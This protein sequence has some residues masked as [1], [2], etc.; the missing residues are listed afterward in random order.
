MRQQKF[1]NRY[2]EPRVATPNLGQAQ[3]DS[4]RSLLEQ[5][6]KETF[7]E[8][9][10]IKDY[11][12][13]KFDLEFVKIEMGEPKYDEHYAKAQKLTLDIPLRAIVRLKNKANGSEKE[14]E[15]FLADMPVMTSHGTFVINGVERVIVPQLA[16]S[17]GVF[18]T[19]EE[20]K[21]KRHFGAKIIPARGAWIEI[22][23]AADNEIAVRIDRK[24][25]FPAVSLLRVLG[26]PYDSDLKSLFSHTPQEKQWIES[27]IEKDT[28][29]TVDEAY[30]EIHKRL[31]DGDL[32]TSANAREYIDS[33]FSEER[34]DLSRVGRYRFNQRF[35]KSLDEKELTRKTLSL[36]DVVTVLRQVIKLENDPEAVEDN[37]DHLGS[38]RVRYVGEML[39]SRLRV[40]LTHMKRNIQDRMSTIDAEATMPVQFVNPRPLQARIKEFFTTNQLSQFAQQENALTELEHL[41][42]L[43]AL[44]P[45]GLTRERAGFEVRDVHPSHY[46][47][48]CP[49]Q[50][51]EGPNIGLI[52]RLAQFARLN[53]FGMIETPY[54]K[55][56]DGK[57]TKEVVY[58]N[59]AEEEKE[60]IAHAG[61]TLK[62]DGTIQGDLVEVRLNGGPTRVPRK[63][64][65]YIDVAPEQPFSI[66]TS[67]IPFLEHDDANRALMGSNMQ[68]Q[69]TPCIIPEAP[70]VATGIEERA[71]K[72]TGR[73][74]YALEDGVVSAVDGKQVKVKNAKGKETTYSLV[75]F[76]RTNGFTALHQRPTVSVGDKVKKGD[77]LADTSTSDNGQLALGQN[78]LV[79]FMC[80][81]GANYE[82]AIIISER[83]V[84]DS[85]FSSIHIEEFV[86][87]VR[88]T[89]LG[90]EETTHDIPN[91]SEVKLRNLDEDGIVRVGS[92]VRAGDILVGKITPKG[93]TQLTPE[94]RLLRSIFG[95]KARDVKDSS[96]RMENGKRGRI[97]G[98][99]VF[100]REAGHNLESGII[101]R[102][103]IEVAQLRAVSVGDK[104]A[105]RHGNKGVISRILPEEDMPYMAD[106]R[107]VDVILTPLGVPS[108]MNLGQIL[109]LHLGLAANTLNYQAI[110]PPFAGA[111][112]GEIREELK[113]AG[114]NESGKMTL[115][116]GR[117]GEKFEQDVSV[118]YMYIL[119]LHHMVED[120]IHMRS[121]GPYSLITQQ[122]LGGKAQGGGQRFG[123]MEVWALLGY[124]AAY[125]LREMLTIKSDDIQGR[126]AAFDAI[127]RGERISHHY[128][129]A[130]FNVLLHT[131][132]GLA[133]DIELM[134]GGERVSAL[135]KTPGADVSDFDNVR[136]RPA[137]PER[138][139][140]WSHGEVTKPETIN[141]RTQRPE[142]NSLFDEKIF[143]PEKDY[144]CY[145][146]KYRGI[147]YKGITCEK[148][149]VEITRAIV[150]RER[151]GHVDLAV[152]VAHVWFL[153]AIPS[154]LAM[155][156]GISGGDLEKV[157]YFAGYVVTTVHKAEK[158]RIIQELE[159]EYKTK[160]KNLVDEKSKEKM[161]ELFLEAKRDIEA[162]HVG[163]VLDEPRYHRYAIKYGAM[164]E[165]GIGA[166]AIYQL[167]RGLDLKQ[168]V[169][170]TE[171]AL[172][173]AGAAER[174][175]LSKRLSTLRSMVRANV[176]PEWMFLTR[177]P[178][179]PPGLRPM[180]ALDG[181]RHATSDVNDLYRRVINRNNRLKKL[182]EINA[183][184]VILRNEKRILQEAVDA[185]I[186]NSIRHG[187]AAYSATTQARTRP[188]KSLSDNLKGKHGLFRQNLLGKRVDYSGRSVIVVGPELKLNQCGLPKH[189]ALELFRPF[190]IGQLLQKELAYNIR[191]AGRLIDEG[192]PEV[193]AI[194]EE[195]IRD[196][197]VLLNR[198][199]TLHRLGIQAFQPILIEGNAIQ[200]HPMVC[201]AF[202]ADF[203]GDQMAVHVPL[204]PEAQAEA[205]EIMAA[206]KNVLKPG[207][208]EPVVASKLL[209]I[210]LGS[211]WM[212]K[213]VEG[214]KGEGRAFHSPNAAIL[215]YDHG[216]VG[217]Q[218]KI[219][220]MPS[221]KEKYAQFGGQL[222]ETTV[223]RLL[224][225]T[226]FPS[227]Y[228]YVNASIDKK[229][230]SKLVDDLIARYG[231]EKIPEILDRIK[232]FGF[233]YVTQSGIT[234]SLDD[235]KIPKEK[236]EIVATAQKKSDEIMKHWQDGLLSEE[237]RYRMNIEVWHGAKSDVE[238][239][240]PGTLT[241]NGPVSDMLKSGARGSVAQVTQ[242]AG[243]KGLIASPTGEAI[244]FPITKS[245]KEGLSPIEYFITTHGS[246]KGLSDT[247]LNTAKAGYLTRRLFDVAQDVVVSEDDCGTKE[248]LTIN[249]ES[250]SGIGTFLAQN[251]HGRYLAHDIE[252]GGKVEYKKGH[253][254]THTDAKRIEELGVPSVY[255]RS[256]VA[257]KSFKGVCAKCYGADLGTMR[258][259]S[260]GEAVGTV[261]AQAIGEPGTQLTM[262]TFHAGGAASVGGDITQGLPRVEEIFERR[263][264][265]NPAVIATVGGEVID[266]KDDG[267]EKI[268]SVA[269]DV[270][271]MK[272]GKKGKDAVEY[273]VHYRRI[274]LVKVGDKV[275]KGQFLTDGSADLSELFKYAGKEK[276]LAYIIAE[277]VKIYELQG[278]NISIKHLEVIVRQMF[279]R[280]KITNPGTT[281]YSIGDVVAETEL[282]ATN[283]RIKAAGGEAA[284]GEGL[285]MGI[286]DVS[287]SR[288]SFLSAASFQNTTRMLIKASIG[289][290][291]DKLEGLKENVII[292][293]L[294]PAGTGFKGSPKADL[295]QKYSP[296]PAEM[297]AVEKTEA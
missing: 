279:S 261:A 75:N 26:A 293:R 253:F 204:S 83:L 80:W 55:V 86:C 135:R 152:P 235:I 101:K 42:T 104:L 106:G 228:P 187:G 76:V 266:I 36:D 6:V 122:P 109:E 19:A 10:P 284:K 173:D 169:Q 84:K 239:L 185:L 35:G 188:L 54:A 156:L 157:V 199:P 174:E 221:E 248:G 257:C 195:V 190:V 162:I 33:I 143:G 115:F 165:A 251:I 79:A 124:G 186:D 62:E 176:R 218:A 259:V 175:K 39:Q 181:G 212:T 74:H 128:A 123:E 114:F 3:L 130:S 15:I 129:P 219:K 247:A 297:P 138:I 196:K 56:V 132:R 65:K 252:V 93:E 17:Y 52:L 118:G 192:V 51:P 20:V 229:G 255:V 61:I 203:D 280:V 111:T 28:A 91:V 215:A 94:E 90:P 205:R 22:E 58:L 163:A 264:P 82:D 193:W 146:G 113:K 268:I 194:L 265:R 2:R 107:P 153:R 67:M 95:D 16:R 271:H 269:P 161:K 282:T 290:A 158:E 24:R 78:A 73:L 117:T 213:E 59:A 283:E 8:F 272:A 232:N 141:Y 168:M 29:K 278:A 177:I 70:L 110:C 237:E 285:I 159:V 240:M 105:G 245:M 9:T 154:R 50:T 206:P 292:G 236:A 18:F 120:K 127:V 189:M 43:S 256:P 170:D 97:I 148:C 77:L 276:T 267:K 99:K 88:D 34:Y 210:L 178:V 44:G 197:Y 254:V 136:I 167:C 46:G 289:G 116:D 151:M 38:R 71:A 147:R 31:R 63:E 230:L 200:L 5:G 139:L 258:P 207:N 64:V 270:E 137:S 40:G 121:I 281:E 23:A 89:K 119:K 198:A 238:K 140:E 208:G 182:I 21:G 126:S 191:G 144:E 125:T 13:K 223:G 209:D 164:F 262:R 41:R 155:V 27:A 216:V 241:V 295:V 246:R 222:F 294:I 201:P 57:V 291:M 4:Y 47:R 287:L 160:M 149:G 150:R 171:A 1:F 211:Y 30:I 14:Q 233:R 53:E 275:E 11:S 142:K 260:L 72:D 179:I 244:E 25:K 263:A 85:K 234:W 7:K 145:C 12:G 133:L 277:V 98:V 224:F 202:N 92:E 231:L 81:S 296:R 102:I 131:L 32:A 96:L 288:A 69:S 249:R 184:D 45:G 274:P 243:M 134:R 220:V 60:P 49:I 214:M 225:N 226:V 273:T 87:N 37:I 66:A 250:A 183:P 166:E 103:H 108:R 242:M 100:S 286:L 48:L 180:V 227:D 68:K 217:F 112:E 172:E